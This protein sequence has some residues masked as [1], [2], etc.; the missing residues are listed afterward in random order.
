MR[1]DGA[2]RV[3]E[4]NRMS[5]GAWISNIQTKIISIVGAIRQIEGL[6]HELQVH[7][8]AELDVLR[9]AH[10]EFEEGVPA[11][12]IILRNRQWRQW[13]AQLG[14]AL[15]LSVEA[16]LEIELSLGCAVSVA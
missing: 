16:I 11:K 5:E 3:D 14:R 6:R 2:G 10:I 7:A 12:R 1:D 8:L 9:K 4:A 15:A 13:H